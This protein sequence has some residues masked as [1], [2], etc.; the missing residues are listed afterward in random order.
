MKKLFSILAPLL[1]SLFFFIPQV[2][3]DT[4]TG[5]LPDSYFN[6][7][8]NNEYSTL[9]T[10]VDNYMQQN[11]LSYYI[12][13]WGVDIYSNRLYAYT[14]STLPVFAFTQYEYRLSWRSFT[15]SSQSFYINLNSDRVNSD[16]TSS[17]GFQNIYVGNTTY[18]TIYTLIDT[19]INLTADF[20]GGN[21]YTIHTS[22]GDFSLS[23]GVKLPTLVELANPTPSDNTPLLTQFFTISIEKLQTIC[24]FIVSSYIYLAVIVIFLIYCSIYL[25]RRLK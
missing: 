8:T 12:I 6:Y 5:T 18:G 9:K 10:Y 4:Y 15:N 23:N 1:V 17:I 11:N 7:N 22:Y 14:Y 24:D 3:A 19:N 16:G 20:T 21:I 25:L 13:I 2:K